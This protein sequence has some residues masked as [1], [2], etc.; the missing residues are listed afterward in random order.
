MFASSISNVIS[1]VLPRI[2]PTHSPLP[3]PGNFPET[4]PANWFVI[5][6]TKIFEIWPFFEMFK[7]GGFENLR[8]PLSGCCH[9]TLTLSKKLRWI[10]NNKTT[11]AMNQNNFEKIFFE[12]KIA[13]FHTYW[14]W[15]F[16]KGFQFLNGHFTRKLKKYQTFH[17]FLK[18]N[19][20]LQPLI[21]HYIESKQKHRCKKLLTSASILPPQGEEILSED[22]L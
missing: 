9:K 19:W 16:I 7:F 15:E 22:G 2:H 12:T 13:I 1:K 10:T 6:I 11:E 8:A 5:I 14:R 21:A 4:L 18:N 20:P 3:P 17:I